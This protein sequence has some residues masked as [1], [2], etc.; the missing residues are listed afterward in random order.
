MYKSSMLA[1]STVALFQCNFQPQVKT[2]V[3]FLTSQVNDQFKYSSIMLSKSCC[4]MRATGSQ[5]KTK[6]IVPSFNPPIQ[7]HG[8]QNTFIQRLATKPAP[9]TRWL[10]SLHP[11]L[12][13]GIWDEKSFTF[14]DLSNEGYVRP[15]PWVM[16]SKGVPSW[17]AVLYQLLARMNGHKASMLELYYLAAEWIPKLNKDPATL[18]K[19]MG[20]TTWP[21]YAQSC[22]SGLVDHQFEKHP[23]EKGLHRIKKAS[24]P[25]GVNRAPVTVA[26]ANE[27]ASASE[28]RPSSTAP[29]SAPPRRHKLPPHAHENPRS[30][31]Q[32]DNNTP[33]PQLPPDEYQR[34]NPPPYQLP[35][36]SHLRPQLPHPSQRDPAST[37]FDWAETNHRFLPFPPARPFTLPEIPVIERTLELAYNLPEFQM[38]GVSGANLIPGFDDLGYMVRLP[39]ELRAMADQ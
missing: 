16:N 8:Q 27:Q 6:R 21:M 13:R 39:V 12:Q 5:A 14:M 2:S 11:P 31:S 24:E 35:A 4:D 30:P 26:S 10:T 28:A 33:L 3:H 38:E 1:V 15:A 7:F 20:K 19:G 17:H 34:I 32:Q 9:Q 22:R 18:L 37:L 25:A 29:A 36:L 23:T